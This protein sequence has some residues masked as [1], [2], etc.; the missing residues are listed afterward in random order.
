VRFFSYWFA[1]A[2]C[3]AGAAVGLRA[4]PAWGGD[5]PNFIVFLADDLG[6]GDLGCYGR[7]DIRTPVLDGL[8]GEGVR[9]TAHY[10]NGPECT[11]T[12]VA[13]LTGRYPQ[14]IG[15]LECAIGT[16]NVGRYDDAIRLAQRSDLGLPTSEV[17]IAR[18]L[19]DG[20]Y[21]TAIVGK[22]H[23]GYEPKFA[24]HLQGFDETFYCI[25][26]GMD[27]FHYLDNVAGYNLFQ[28]GQPIRREGYFTD[29]ITIEATRF[30][31]QH[32]ETRAD[33]PFFL[34]V[35]YT[36]PHAPY[37]GPR[38]RRENP[39]PI[40]SP[41]WN[42][43]NAPPDVYRAMIERMDQSIGA[44]LGEVHEH[45][46]SERTLVIFASD[47]GGTRSARNTP[48]SGHKGSTSEGGIRVPAIARWPG[49]L[50]AGLVSHQVCVTFDF[51]ASIAAAAGVEAPE[52]R[53]FE[54]IDIIGHVARR[55]ADVDRTLFWRK[56]RGDT[57]WRAAREGPMKYV[58]VE[59][60]NAST[61]YLFDVQADI[62]EQNDLKANQPDEFQR[63]RT[64]FNQWEEEVRRNRRGRN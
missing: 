22:W 5:R 56:P 42:Q 33:Q 32:A 28:N 15:G 55:A 62:A 1:L 8:A 44:I 51:T 50:P 30:L 17:T 64:L 38:D 16:G 6:Y 39:L 18:L 31:K 46:L 26:G 4:V 19:Q 10:A 13:L 49:V 20:G 37:Q 21:R 53:P 43:S 12:R 60:G 61:E 58:S 52:D 2:A 11:P 35:P 54:G 23:L 40:D 3:F 7:E 14:W 57:I 36:A 48:L 63:L 29:L 47:N 27:Y 25:G 45:G 24:P 59:R 34:Y 9:F 41:L